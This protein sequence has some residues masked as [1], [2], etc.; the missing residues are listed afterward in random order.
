MSTSSVSLG[1]MNAAMN[2]LDTSAWRI[3]RQAA[4]RPA[5]AASPATP[6][7]TS[8]PSLEDDMVSQLQAKNAFLANLRVFQTGDEMLGALIDV[9][10]GP[11]APAA[12]AWA[13]TR[14]TSRV[15]GPAISGPNF[16]IC[17]CR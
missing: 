9:K 1:G 12:Y 17:S 10:G 14:K 5:D 11:P 6:A 8:S 3:A 4:Q 16:A 7:A 2:A 13:A 15:G